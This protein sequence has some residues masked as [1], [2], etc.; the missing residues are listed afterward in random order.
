MLPR[1]LVGQ[2]VEG[3]HLT[4]EEAVGGR[5]PSLDA[6]RTGRALSYRSA[7]SSAVAASVRS[8]RYFTITGA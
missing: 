1:H 4:V 3:L 8:S 5:R 7:S 2:P 6:R